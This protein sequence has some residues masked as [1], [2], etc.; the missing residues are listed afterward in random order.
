MG[1]WVIVPVAAWSN[2]EGKAPGFSA[3]W[4]TRIDAA[5][6]LAKT[7]SRGSALDFA[8]PQLL[9]LRLPPGV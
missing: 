5:D 7:H 6:G 1:E 9:Q 4:Q 2:R 3:G 8:A